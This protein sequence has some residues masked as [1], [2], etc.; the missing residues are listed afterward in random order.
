M[1]AIEKNIFKK[2]KSIFAT[3]RAAE[4]KELVQQNMDIVEVRQVKWIKQLKERL[5]L[6]KHW[7]QEV[8]AESKGYPEQYKNAETVTHCHVEKIFRC[9]HYTKYLLST[10]GF[11]WVL[12]Q[13]KASLQLRNGGRKLENI[14]RKPF[15]I[16][17]NGIA[18]K[19]IL[20]NRSSEFSVSLALIYIQKI[21][22][23]AASFD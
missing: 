16:T 6:L 18:E 4:A 2:R 23:Q 20:E 10:G 1:T 21:L 11:R 13:W 9:R 3:G 19:Q 7:L 22:G 15:I 5:I 17:K 14:L 8:L 12:H